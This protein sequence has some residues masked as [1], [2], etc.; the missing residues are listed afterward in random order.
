MYK[1]VMRLKRLRVER[2]ITQMA[3]AKKLGISYSAYIQKENGFRPFTQWEIERL[4]IVLNT[5]Y[6]NVFIKEEKRDYSAERVY[7]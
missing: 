1:Q 7:I 4:L 5:T 2:N 3:L 6:D